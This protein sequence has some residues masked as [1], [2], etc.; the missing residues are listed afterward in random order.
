[1]T[2][3]VFAAVVTTLSFLISATEGFTFT[4]LGDRG[5]INTVAFAEESKWEGAG[6]GGYDGSNPNFE[7]QLVEVRWEIFPDGRVTN[8]VKGVKGAKCHEETAAIE[9]ALGV[10]THTEP[11]EEMYENEIVIQ[12]KNTLTNSWEGDDGSGGGGSQFSSW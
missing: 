12:G 2:K 6:S 10:V 3:I 7:G 5:R 11:T 8:L 1:M 9:K 4:R